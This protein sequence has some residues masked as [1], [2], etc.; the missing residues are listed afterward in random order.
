MTALLYTLAMAQVLTGS[1]GAQDP[2][3]LQ[4]RAALD[5]AHAIEVR[6]HYAEALTAYQQAAKLADHFGKHDPRM[7]TTYNRLAIAYDEAGFSAD[8][9][10]TYRHALDLVQSA[11]GKQ[12]SE[13][14]VIEANLGTSYLRQGE[15]APA[16]NLLQEALRIETSLPQ[17]DTLHRAMMQSCLAEVQLHRHHYQEAENSIEA[18]LPVIEKSGQ[19][20]DLA[21]AYITMGN[22]RRQQHR[23]GDALESI[24]KAIAILEARFGSDHPLLLR[25]LEYQ[26]MVYAEARHADQA[27]AAFQRAETICNKS[28]PAGHPSRAVLLMIHS[29]FLREIGE[30]TEAKAMAA[31]AHAIDRDIETREGLSMMVDVSAFRK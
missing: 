23:F 8:A 5:R 31:Q 24:T 25:P 15:L 17:P 16:G 29:A 13:Y 20:L 14:P 21:V 12:N 2:P 1:A 22:V 30:K 11:A 18:A 10:R 7:W 27:E 26:G 28:L 6:G 19:T 9:I 3:D 4:W